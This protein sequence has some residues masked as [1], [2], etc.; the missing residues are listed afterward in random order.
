MTADDFP[1]FPSAFF[2]GV[3]TRLYYES[4]DFYTTH[5]GFRTVEERNAWVRLLHPSGAQLVLLEEEADHTPSEL[6]CASVGRGLW[7]TLE[8]ADVALERNALV[9]EGVPVQDVP[10]EKWWCEGSFAV[11]DP[12]GVL[13]IITRRASVVRTA[14]R[15]SREVITSA[16]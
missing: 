14:P 10:S 16:A 7:L 5:L 13:V 1:V 6:V 3:V 15:E 12:N 8:V 4:W 11:T 9:S 2:A